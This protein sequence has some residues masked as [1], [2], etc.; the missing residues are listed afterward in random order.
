[1]STTPGRVRPLT[2]LSRLCSLW[3]GELTILPEPEFQALDYQEP[4]I[5]G[6][7][8]GWHAVDL[9]RRRV[10]A[11]RGH[12][13]PGCV[14]HEM[15]HL[16]LVEAE[17]EVCPDEWPWF[18]WEVVLARQVGCYP[19]WSKSSSTYIVGG[20]CQGMEWGRLKPHERRCLIT[21]RIAHAKTIGILS[22][23]GEPLCTRH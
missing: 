10:I 6:A 18:G 11:A 9:P 16:F 15:G 13:C 2:Y 21:D 12:V 22:Q 3:G 14:I 19:T 17:P 4:G 5:S 1:M 23:D 8:D 20:S 7:P